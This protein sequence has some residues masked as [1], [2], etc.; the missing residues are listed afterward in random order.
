MSSKDKYMIQEWISV[1]VE[2]LEGSD[3]EDI[4]TSKMILMISEQSQDLESRNQ[5]LIV[6]I[7][8]EMFIRKQI[9]KRRFKM[10]LISSSVLIKKADKN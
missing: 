2:N 6:K 9:M 7:S 5:Q 3:L 1:L 10:N 4:L 8:G